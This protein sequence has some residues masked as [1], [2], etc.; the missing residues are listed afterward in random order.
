MI[1][2]ALDLGSNSFLSLIVEGSDG[3]ILKV[4][5]D[6]VEIVRLGQGV[7]KTKQL[8]PEALT[9]ARTCLEKF[10]QNLDRFRVEKIKAVATSAA[11]D[12]TNSEELFKIGRDLQIP[13][14]II[15]GGREAETTY[16]GAIFDQDPARTY[17][18]IDIGGGSTEMILGQGQKFLFKKSI[19]V[20]AVRY[21]ERFIAGYPMTSEELM[22]L[23]N[24]I[25]VEVQKEAK[26]LTS[27]PIDTVVAVAG[28][29]TSLAAV[30][31]GGFIESK[32][33]GYELNRASLEK[34][35][36]KLAQS[37]IDEKIRWGFEPKRADIIIVGVIVLIEIMKILGI[38]KIKTSTKGVRYGVALNLLK[39]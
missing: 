1:V 14:E 38:D 35:K 10:R 25:S 27:S 33:H 24:A 37:Q 28:T 12:A 5:S 26:S 9:R 21:S 13:I 31:I 22:T 32:V 15:D 17:A 6:E 18:V 23:E 20:G 39:E 19:N 2:A 30:E 34:W 29:P 7:D 16:K 36:V 4:L 11:R 8:H 3:R